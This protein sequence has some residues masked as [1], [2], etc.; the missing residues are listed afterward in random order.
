MFVNEGEN[1]QE[2]EAKNIQDFLDI[3]TNNLESC[4]VKISERSEESIKL[5]NFEEFCN[6]IKEMNEKGDNIDSSKLNSYPSMLNNLN[7]NNIS[8]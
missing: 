3:I 1:E 6:F 5:P 7:F 4:L 8:L 2:I